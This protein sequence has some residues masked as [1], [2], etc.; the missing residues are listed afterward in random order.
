MAFADALL[1]EFDHETGVTR[2]LLERLP[3][4]KFGWKPHEKSMSLGRL[5]SHVAET[6]TWLP[7]TVFKSEINWDTSKPFEAKICATR[8]E[9]LQF[10]D[11]A[12]KAA[13]AALASA[14]DA[15]LLQPWSFKKDGQVLFSQPKIGIIRGMVINHM[16]HHRGQLSVY[17]R[18]N[19]VPLPSMYGP[20]ADEPAF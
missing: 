1:P 2:R 5:A 11:D 4:D 13:R 12:Q 17:L 7:E 19:N 15:E 20:S 8:A 16:I 9:T 18:E 14:S 6:L 10:F 3:D